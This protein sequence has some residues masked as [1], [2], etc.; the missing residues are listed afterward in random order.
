MCFSNIKTSLLYTAALLAVGFFAC[1]VTNADASAALYKKN[2]S[3]FYLSGSVLSNTYNSAEIIKDPRV[4]ALLIDGTYDFNYDTEASMSWHPYLTGGVGM[5]VAQH[6]DGMSSISS[7]DMSPLFRIGGGVTY[8]LGDE[9]NLSLDYKAG[10]TANPSSSD[11][12][13]T[14]RSQEPVDLQMLNMGMRYKF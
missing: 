11:Y 4:Y 13:F 2:D 7:G 10:L 1:F 6:Q 12:M 14:G 9:W 8:L 3:A 5:S